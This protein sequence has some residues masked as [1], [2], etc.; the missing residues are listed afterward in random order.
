M[1]NPFSKRTGYTNSKFKLVFALILLL[2]INSKKFAHTQPC[3]LH[4]N[5]ISINNLGDTIIASTN[6]N[7]T[8]FSVDKGNTWQ[9]YTH[10]FKETQSSNEKVPLG[11]IDISLDGKNYISINGTKF[12]PIEYSQEINSLFIHDS[13]LYIGTTNDLH[14]LPDSLTLYQVS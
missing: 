11:N 1:S 8:Y 14:K 10:G 4:K 3:G 9:K 7:L 12:Q 2:G 5:I 6:E 13:I